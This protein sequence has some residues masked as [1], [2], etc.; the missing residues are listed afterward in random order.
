MYC[1]KCHRKLNVI[2][3]SNRYTHGKPRFK[4]SCPNAVRNGP[5]D[6]QAVR[7]VEMDE[8]IQDLFIKGCQEESYDDFFVHSDTPESQEN[9]SLILCDSGKCCNIIHTMA[10]VQLRLACHNLMQAQGHEEL[11]GQ[12]KI[13]PGFNLPARYVLHTVG[14]IIED[15]VTVEDEHLLAS[16]YNSCLSLA[17]ES[18]CQSIAFCCISTGVFR[19]PA[20]REAQIAVRTVK[21]YLRK[22]NRIQRVIFNVFKDSDLFIYQKL[23]LFYNIG[24]HPE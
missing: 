24:S 16:C 23:L 3:E 14:P 1:P 13:T 8:Y 21:D 10:G 19:F 20:D 4:Y 18:N 2:S 5:C 9:E 6:Y 12:A 15:E 17:A 7:S 11:T 22:D